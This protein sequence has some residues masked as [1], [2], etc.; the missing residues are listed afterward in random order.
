MVLLGV[1][2]AGSAAGGG[3][4]PAPNPAIA[5]VSIHSDSKRDYNEL[6][7]MN[8]DGTNQKVLVSYSAKKG[9]S[10]P[11]ISGTMVN[12]PDWSPDGLSLVFRVYG[13]GIW[14]VNRDG[15]GLRRVIDH[16][17]ANWGDPAWSPLPVPGALGGTKAR[18]AFMHTTASSWT[19]LF[20]VSPDGSGLV[21][22]T[23]TSSIGEGSPTWSPSGKR[24]AFDMSQS[25]SAAFMTLGL[26][27]FETDTYTQVAPGGALAGRTIIN[28]SWSKT[29]ENRIAVRTTDSGGSNPSTQD[30]DLWLLDLNDLDH[31]VN[32]T[33]TTGEP[34]TGVREFSPSWSPD[35][36]QIVFSATRYRDTVI[37]VVN[38]DGTG[39][40]VISS[41]GRKPVWRR[42]P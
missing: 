23:N 17:R 4:S 31:P 1:L 10:S 40:H 42:N 9:T 32:L 39:R 30:W 15:T 34:V 28:P 29:S 36:S 12:D 19:D 16:A 24:L 3:T 8:A 2:G 14:A 18:I 21:Q 41:E 27:D 20:L 33:N 5:Y 6:K 13:D 35:D 38:A 26:Y 37:E 11:I 7:V 22:V 25:G